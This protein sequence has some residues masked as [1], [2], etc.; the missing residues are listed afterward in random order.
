VRATVLGDVCV[1][2][3]P[4]AG[5]IERRLFACLVVHRDNPVERGALIE[6]V[7]GDR[8]PQNATAAL[9]T[10]VSR[11]RDLLGADAVRWNGWAYAL[12]LPADTL[13]AAAFEAGIA[14]ARPLGAA[15][16]VDALDAVL[17]LWRG[18]PFGDLAG[19]PFVRAEAARLWALRADAALRRLS[20]LQELGRHEQVIEGSQVLLAEDPWA[21]AP[22]TLLARSLAATGRAREALERLADHRRHQAE[23]AGLVAG[24]LVARA[25]DDILAGRIEPQTTRVVPVVGDVGPGDGATVEWIRPVDLSTPFI[26]REAELRRLHRRFQEALRGEPSVVVVE[27]PAGIG[28]SRLVSEALRRAGQLG[29][30]VAATSCHEGLQLPFESIDRVLE[31]LPGATSPRAVSPAPAMATDAVERVEFES[32][33][34]AV[35]RAER[36]VDAAGAGPVAIS[37]D[38]AHWADEATAATLRILASRLASVRRRGPL[39]LVVVVARR[40]AGGVQR[41]GELEREAR[42]ELIDLRPLSQVETAGLIESWAGTRPAADLVEAASESGGNA[43]A[44]LTGLRQLHRDHR[45]RLDRGELSSPDPEL[46]FGAEVGATVEALTVGMSAGER[47]LLASIALLRPGGT[48][49]EAA[50]LLGEPL[51]GLLDVLEAADQRG[52][53]TVRHGR[54]HFLHPSYRSSL[55]ASLTGT[56]RN[57]IHHG[58]A[59]RL[60]QPVSDSEVL[61]LAWHLRHAGAAVA[62]RHRNLFLTAA[63]LCFARSDWY[64]ATEHY[65]LALAGDP[66]PSPAVA[67]RAGLAAFRAHDSVAA[68]GWFERAAERARA[69]GDLDGEASAVEALARARLTS[70]GRGAVDT[71][72]LVRVAEALDDLARR[73]SAPLYA[74]LAEVSYTRR[75]LAAGRHWIACARRSMGVTPDEGAAASVS[76]AAGL[77]A[78]GELDLGRATTHFDR[79]DAEAAQ[80][81]QPW[82][83]SWAR[84]R[85]ALARLFAGDLAGASA[86]VARARAVA[87]PSAAWADLSLALTVEATVHAARGDRESAV[88]T[89]AEAELVW[90]RAR[91]PFVV[92]LLF[93][94]LV[95]CRLALGDHDEAMRVVDRWAETPVGGHAVWRLVVLAHAG[96]GDRARTLLGER[97]LVVP[98]GPD[99]TLAHAHRPIVAALLARRLGLPG[100]AAQA[101]VGLLTLQERG[102]VYGPGWPEPVSGLISAGGGTTVA[103]RRLVADQGDRS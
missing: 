4:L 38:D 20:A 17:A 48:P 91:Y 60:A 25:E 32:R 80:A 95:H 66:A 13:D 101:R 71:A 8:A 35:Q 23:E 89:A 56:A 64:A 98:T 2:G 53:V 9:H 69:V 61:V 27:G 3:R 51:D 100:L 42:T 90:R 15:E 26:G 10:Q 73:G 81:G 18:E 11:L 19:E 85:L 84:G 52:L 39:P 76:F 12:E 97:P 34:Q 22:V 33:R 87:E 78:L 79:C 29:L 55:R 102:L 83:R 93:P 31:Q 94:L 36:M 86:G 46:A 28:K 74:L 5:R 82:I 96:E 1:D 70:G 65:R 99:L 30:V 72:E 6:A 54:I 103:V 21:D 92:H 44:V 58:I 75:D 57:R 43:L 88:V 62:P 50:Q 16:Q 68:I 41:Q 77:Q 67:V 24:P 47:R 37:V 49:A 63:D 14:A 45:L 40:P 7:W 59:G